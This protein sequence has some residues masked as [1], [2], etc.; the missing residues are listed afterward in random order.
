MKIVTISPGNNIENRWLFEKSTPNILEFSNYF[1]FYNVGWATKGFTPSKKILDAYW[2][3]TAKFRYYIALKNLI[4]LF[5]TF[6]LV[7]N[8]YIVSPAALVYLRTY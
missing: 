6:S 4:N 3:I 1:I 5:Q 8:V 2:E 7:L